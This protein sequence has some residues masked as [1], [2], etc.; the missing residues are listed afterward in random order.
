MTVEP[1]TQTLDAIL[2]DFDGLVLDTEETRLEAWTLGLARVGIT[3]DVEAYIR[4]THTPPG[5]MSGQLARNLLVGDHDAQAVDAL[6]RAISADNLRLATARAEMPGVRALI[7]AAHDRGIRTGLVSGS[8]RHWITL[9]LQRLGL[10]D[11]FDVVITREDVS[12]SKPDPAAYLIALHQLAL[13]PASAI[14]IEDSPIGLMAASG[15]GI[16]CA[17]VPN[18]MT[19]GL[20]FVQACATYPSLCDVTVPE[21]VDAALRFQAMAKW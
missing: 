13:S 17:A 11:Q 7:T 6:L 14:A 3:I 15:A 5:Y 2:F 10:L 1:R 4:L 9:H 21:L 12:V 8:G 20:A 18:Q 16:A 19:S